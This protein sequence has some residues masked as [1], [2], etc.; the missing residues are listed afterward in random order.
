MTVQAVCGPATDKDT[1]ICAAGRV[2]DTIS[3][4]TGAP[5]S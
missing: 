4:A 2:I 3:F 1:S 5:R